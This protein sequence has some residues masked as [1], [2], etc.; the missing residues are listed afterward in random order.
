[1]SSGRQAAVKRLDNVGNLGDY[2]DYASIPQLPDG[3]LQ[4]GGTKASQPRPLRT[5]KGAKQM[6]GQPVQELLGR[7]VF[8]G[9]AGSDDR[10][11]ELILY[12]ANK[13]IT[14]PSYGA[15]KLNKLLYFSDFTA[16]YQRGKSITGCEYM[17]LPQGPVPRRLMAVR[18]D[19]EATRDAHMREQYVGTMVQKRLVPLREA[20]LELFSAWEISTVDS[21]I[22]MFWSK[23]AR[24]MSEVSHNRAWRIVGTDKD[25]LP[26]Q[27]VFISNDKPTVH[28]VARLVELAEQHGVQ[29]PGV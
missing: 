23:T 25:A 16:Y 13:C 28:D 17:G 12:I 6:N 18:E 21:M 1:L 3:L 24:L 11:R 19:M 2:D 15:T 27:A 9:D 26:Y 20:K 4:V 29:L 14:D 22:E 10:L 8:G 5:S 7:L